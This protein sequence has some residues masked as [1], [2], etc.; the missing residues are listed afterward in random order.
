MNL[1]SVIV[2]AIIGL[3]GT[4]AGVVVTL[5]VTW[6]REDRRIKR[7]KTEKKQYALTKLKNLLVNGKTLYEQA[8]GLSFEIEYD[9][10]DKSQYNLVLMFIENN[11]KV[12][13]QL[14]ETGVPS[15]R[16]EVKDFLKNA[17]YLKTQ[18]IEGETTK[19]LRSQ[20]P[21]ELEEYVERELEKL[22]ENNRA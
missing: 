13:E 14:I 7:E 8:G 10:E 20:F 4:L 16:K 9:S 5:L 21:K 2:S 17:T 1:D 12:A 22:S 19:W 15:D 18:V 11:A 6:I 3:T